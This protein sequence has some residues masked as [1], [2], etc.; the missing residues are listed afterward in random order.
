MPFYEHTNVCCNFRVISPW[1]SPTI[2]NVSE[3]CTYVITGALWLILV[4]LQTNI[5]VKKLRRGWG[6]MDLVWNT[7]LS[8]GKC[9][10]NFNFETPKQEIASTIHRNTIHPGFPGTILASLG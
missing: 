10:Q 9:K 8:H 7:N 1:A 5:R 3:A 4:V 6:A 2:Q